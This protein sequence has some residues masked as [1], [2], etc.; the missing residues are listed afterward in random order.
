VPSPAGFSFL[1]SSGDPI[2]ILPQTQNEELLYLGYGGDGIPTG[3]FVGNQ[4]TVALKRVEG[5]GDFFSY[6]TDTFGN[7]VVYFN[8]RDGI[9]TND[10]TTVQAGGDAHL[11]WAFTA[12]GTYN[13]VLQASGTLVNGSVGT[14]SAPVTFTFS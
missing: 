9:T 8:T 6:K 4:V 3:V 2:W 12:P 1:G 14:T 11:S 5:P 10:V 7:P 13:V